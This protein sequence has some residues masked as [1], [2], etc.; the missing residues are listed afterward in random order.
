MCNANSVRAWL[1]RSAILLV[2]VLCTPAAEADSTRSYQLPCSISR[3]AVSA[4]ASTIWVTCEDRDEWTKKA[5]EAKWA[6]QPPPPPPPA[7]RIPTRFY[8]VDVSSGKATLLASTVGWIRLLPAPKGDALIAVRN[9]DQAAL[10]RRDRKISELP[11]DASFLAWSAD[12]IR[13]YFYGGTTIQAD[14]WNI[15][16]IYDLRT[17][18]KMKRRLVEPTENIGVCQANGHVFSE[19]PEY[20]NFKG[21]TVEYDSKLTL[22]RRFI[23]FIGS[24]FSAHCLYVA[25]ESDFHGPLPWSVYDV[26]TGKKLHRFEYYSTNNQGDEYELVAWSPTRDEFMLRRYMPKGGAPHSLQVINIASGQVLA[27]VP[28]NE[29]PVTWSSDGT[30]IILG[31]GAK[32]VVMPIGN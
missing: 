11:V 26:R 4:D 15:L 19:T 3:L 8:A 1:W 12:A 16:G 6:K 23:H 31:Q 13:L 20:P 17:G 22:M 14:A 7:N 32:L 28:D 2:A 24:R 10:Y 18:T 27:S 30:E 9:M 5:E 21:S 25:S 29:Q